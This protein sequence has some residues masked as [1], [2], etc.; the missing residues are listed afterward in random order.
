MQPIPGIGNAAAE[1]FADTAANLTRL[2]LDEH[3]RYMTWVLNLPHLISLVM[4]ETLRGSGLT[5]GRLADLGGTTFSKQM[6]VTGEVMS[7]NPELYYH[8][9]HI[10]RHRTELYTALSRSVEHIGRLSAA[11]DAAG[12]GTMMNSWLSYTEASDEQR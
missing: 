2:P 12:F 8:I 7:E 10:N 4:G 6:R 11:E 3:D 9:Q 5:F 1:L